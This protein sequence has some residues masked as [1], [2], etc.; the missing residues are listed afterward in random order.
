[1][2]LYLLTAAAIVL[3]CVFLNKLSDKIGIPMLLAFILL[4][5]LFGTDGILKIH[6]ENFQFAEQICSIAL[7]FIMFYGGFGT[8]WKTAR[9]VALKAFLLSTI[10]V[11]L[12][13]FLTG[14]FCYLV[15]GF[16]WLE[17]L[18][19][20]SV[21]G[22]TDAASVFS[23][24]RSKKMGLKYHT[25]SLLELESGSND[26]SSYMLTMIVLT[27]MT[28]EVTAGSIFR[29]IIFQFGFGIL[30][31]LGMA[32][33][34]RFVLEK[35]T[36]TTAGFDMAFVTGTALL[37]YSFSSMLGG[38]GY[39]SV[40]LCGILLGNTKI[41][42]KKSL[43]N[44]FDGITGLMQMLI[45]FLLGLLS[46]PSEIPKILIPALL[47]FLFLTLIARPLSVSAILSP[48]RCKR[49]QQLLVGFSGLRGAASI[50]FAIMA[51]IHPAALSQDMFHI[52]FCIVLLSIALQGSLLPAVAKKFTMTDTEAD[53]MKT[54][55]DYD[56]AGDLHCFQ[57]TVPKGHAWAGKTL[58]DIVLPPETLIILIIRNDTRIIPDGQTRFVPGDTAVISAYSF[59]GSQMMQ[60]RE[61]KITAGSSLA[62]RPLHE[63]PSESG[64]LVVMIL[65]NDKAIVPGG[66]TIIRRDD[67]LVIHSA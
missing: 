35:V 26:P 54:F 39:L 59:H 51:A 48:F 33:A 42:N 58:Q 11:V 47:I 37:T 6:F 44:F 62:D 10:G 38:N 55:S 5:M 24:L 31:G 12:T 49:N 61:Q 36:F 67:T 63:F 28:S 57:V 8:N 1:M 19:L 14:I 17:S 4:G 3:L 41:H 53:V 23:I 50:V 43:V 66:D 52:V 16:S 60:L 64:E 30:V 32:A 56:E 25:D 20:G 27:I 29:M 2:N 18:L 7:I 45:F 46:T 34:A 15:L 65:R 22:S 13:A 21:I 9:P 40:Y